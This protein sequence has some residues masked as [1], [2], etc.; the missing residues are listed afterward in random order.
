MSGRK[1]VGQIQMKIEEHDGLLKA[2]SAPCTTSPDPDLP[3]LQ[4]CE[5]ALRPRH[6]QDDSMA[7][8]PDGRLMWAHPRT[9][10]QRSRPVLGHDETLPRYCCHLR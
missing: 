1:T 3:L 7:L 8:P 4:C 2:T 10:L 9:S 5:D 6:C